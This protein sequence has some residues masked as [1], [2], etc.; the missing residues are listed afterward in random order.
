MGMARKTRYGMQSDGEGKGGKKKNERRMQTEKRRQKTYEK[1]R[2][3]AKKQN[4]QSF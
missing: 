4:Q 2:E 1:M 3:P